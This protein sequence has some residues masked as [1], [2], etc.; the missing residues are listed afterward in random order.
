MQDLLM[1]NRVYPSKKDDSI[2]PDDDVAAG[3]PLTGAGAAPSSPTS[4][5][6]E[7][8]GSP[9]QD[10]DVSPAP[11]AGA[12]AGS[13]NDELLLASTGQPLLRIPAVGLMFADTLYGAPTLLPELVNRWGA[14]HKILIILTVRQVMPLS[15]SSQLSGLA[16]FQQQVTV[17]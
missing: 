2:T 9:R 3:E 6:E 10:N 7:G 17:C 5:A 14:V 12:A 4:Q 8:M 11:A 1:T 16:A 13:H 15:V